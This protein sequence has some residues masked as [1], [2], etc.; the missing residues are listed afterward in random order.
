MAATDSVKSVD[1]A[2]AILYS[3]CRWT[4]GGSLTHSQS[5]DRGSLN[6]DVEGLAPSKC[7]DYMVYMSLRLR[8]SSFAPL[9]PLDLQL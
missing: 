5:D 6:L 8:G 1:W 3:Q 7:T 4:L 9:T 2:A